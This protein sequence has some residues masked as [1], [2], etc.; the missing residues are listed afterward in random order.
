[1]T[2]V[3]TTAKFTSDPHLSTTKTR[4]VSV[5]RNKKTSFFR[6]ERNGIPIKIM[7]MLPPHAAQ[8]AHPAW[9]WSA[10]TSQRRGVSPSA[11]CAPLQPEKH[12]ATA[13]G[14]ARERIAPHRI[15]QACSALFCRRRGSRR[16]F[17]F[18]S[19]ATKVRVSGENLPP[20]SKANTTRRA[21]LPGPTNSGYRSSLRSLP[22]GRQRHPCQVRLGEGVE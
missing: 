22:E 2:H 9:R 1:M 3:Q 7:N 6:A 10:S 21:R 19:R 12:V 8:A 18:A 20:T 15:L 5:Q 11:P 14:A 4:A 16:A 17:A 13:F